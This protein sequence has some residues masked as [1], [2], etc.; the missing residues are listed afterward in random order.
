MPKK[1]TQRD[2]AAEAG[3]CVA[4]VSL[5]LRNHPSIPEATRE[6]IR[7]VAERLGY[8][9]NPRVAELMGHI[10]RNRSADALGETAALVWTDRRKTAPGTSPQLEAFEQAVR[11][12]LRENGVGLT[13]FTREPDQE[14]DQ[15][16][17]VLRSRGIRGVILV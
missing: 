12:T 14:V 17:R 7:E 1:P 11:D 6:E 13:V 9:P 8:Q 5:A 10:R 3:V 15:I 16:G 4:T 2:I